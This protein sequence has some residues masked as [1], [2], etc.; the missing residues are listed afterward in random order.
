M[1]MYLWMIVL[2]IS[3]QDYFVVTFHEDLAISVLNKSAHIYGEMIF[4]VITYVINL[5]KP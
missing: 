1:Y 3:D 4:Y 5:I 2:Q